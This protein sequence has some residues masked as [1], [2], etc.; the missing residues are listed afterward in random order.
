MASDAQSAGSDG[1]QKPGTRAARPLSP[2]LQ[3][4][5]VQIT[6]FT[7]IMHRFTGMALAAGTLLLTY[8]LVA[9]AIGPEAY[10]AANGFIGSVIGVILLIGWAWSLFYH[11]IN[12][13][14]H[15]VWDAGYGFELDTAAITGWIAI[16]GATVLTLIVFIIAWAL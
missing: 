16:I 13:I 14:R 10:S 6:S 8:W 3:I 5:R 12:G 9:A 2:H 11:L 4:W 7:S 1:G 15:L